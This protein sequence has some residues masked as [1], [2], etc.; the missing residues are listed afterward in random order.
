[1]APKSPMTGRAEQSNPARLACDDA[2]NFLKDVLVLT[3]LLC[4]H[5]I[6]S[7]RTAPFVA[8]KTSP[9]GI[10]VL[11]G[12]SPRGS[13]RGEFTLDAATRQTQRSA[14]RRVRALC[15]VQASHDRFSAC[16]ANE[17]QKR[18]YQT[19]TTWAALELHEYSTHYLVQLVPWSDCRSPGLADYYSTLYFGT[20]LPFETSS[21]ACHRRAYVAKCLAIER[22]RNVGVCR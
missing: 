11:C 14:K 20:L 22:S 9:V 15:R 6:S 7:K 2:Q 21:E 8:P 4:P 18:M 3:I 19:C 13:S 5:S 10:H 1:M 17:A 12:I 16:N